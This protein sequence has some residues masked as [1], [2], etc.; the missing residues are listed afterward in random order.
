MRI[1]TVVACPGTHGV[2]D[3]GIDCPQDFADNIHGF[4]LLSFGAVDFG[5]F[6]GGGFQLQQ[7][8][9]ADGWVICQVHFPGSHLID[10]GLEV[11]G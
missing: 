2:E 4:L 1:F 8:V 5:R 3:V 7:E 11:V 6:K 9:K 10:G